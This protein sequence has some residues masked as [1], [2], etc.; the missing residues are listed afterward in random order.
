MT[1]EDTIVANMVSGVVVAGVAA[2]LGLWIAQRYTRKREEAQAKL[3]RDL[4]AAAELYRVYGD[5]FAA[6]K[7]WN[8]HSRSSEPTSRAR[9]SRLGPPD[10]Q[11]RSELLAAAAQAEGGFEALLIRLALEHNL[12]NDQRAVLWCLRSAS[13]Q[14]RRAMRAGEP[15]LWWKSDIHRGDAGRDGYRAYQAFKKLA[16]LTGCMLL[17]PSD[18]PSIESRLL[19][20]RQVTSSVKEF[21]TSDNRFNQ[22]IEE[23]RTARVG[24]PDRAQEHWEW[25]VVAEQLPPTKVTTEHSGSRAT[26]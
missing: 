1:V 11:R 24:S 17:H 21:T 23:E 7:V 15:L 19:A 10:D 16:S 26:S 3:E 22:V 18:T 25:I 5:F 14:L 12:N 4:A 2:L 6:W 20:L 9:M 13:Q 8:A